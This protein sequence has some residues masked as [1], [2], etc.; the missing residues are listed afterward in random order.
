[1]RLLILLF[2]IMVRDQ[3]S[4]VGISDLNPIQFWPPDKPTFNQKKIPLLLPQKFYQRF[5][6]DESLYNRLDVAFSSQRY[7]NWD[8]G[9][10]Y[11]IGDLVYDPVTGLRWKSIT[12]ANLANNPQADITFVNWVA[13]PM[14]STTPVWDAAH[15]YNSGESVLYRYDVGYPYYAYRSK[16]DANLGR[17]PRTDRNFGQV[18]T[19]VGVWTRLGSVYSFTYTGAMPYTSNRVVIPYSG[20]AGVHNV[21]CLL[22]SIS[23]ISDG[24]AK[25]YF[26]DSDFNILATSLPADIST[27]AFPSGDMVSPDQISYVG[28]DFN[29]PTS[30]S[31]PHQ[32]SFHCLVDGVL[33]TGG[34]VF[35]DLS[36]DWEPITEATGRYRLQFLLGGTVT[37]FLDF[38]NIRSGSKHQFVTWLFSDYPEFRDAR[39]RLNILD[40]DNNIVLAQ[41]D[42]IDVATI[43]VN[44]PYL[45]IQY[46][47]SDDYAGVAMEV[48]N[49]QYYLPLPAHFYREVEI[50]EGEDNKLTNGRIVSL[51]RQLV[52]KR[53]LNII[54]PLPDWEHKKIRRV[55]TC[56]NVIIDDLPWKWD[57]ADP[58]NNPDI[59]TSQLSYASV[60]LTQADSVL[61]NLSKY[62][63]NSGGR[64][65]SGEFANPFS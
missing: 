58:Y 32:L 49:P 55:L 24:F 54:D 8:A 29:N 65:F 63:A 23:G 53:L 6:F 38:G 16:T 44:E 59:D 39:V 64:V 1:M 62:D 34:A 5:K 13:D 31:N 43:G 46:T 18:A 17:Y 20:A 25:A 40:V 12:N 10:S 4:I 57:P 28:L 37:D 27:A 50:V 35:A 22:N 47:N 7:E 48:V 42:C 15:S 2:L 51:R 60:L 45:T 3:T 52:T 21:N 11:S 36:I 9:I 19:G 33:L 14:A 26:L 61:I 56:D 30:G 41:S